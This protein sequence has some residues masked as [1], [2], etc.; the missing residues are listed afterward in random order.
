MA[1]NINNFPSERDG[2]DKAKHDL[3]KKTI[4]DSEVDILGLTELGRNEFNIPYSVRPS[5]V[6]QTWVKN[7]L[8]LSAW[9]RR[10]NL[11][12]YEPGV[13][14]KDRSTAHTIKRGIDERN[15]GRWTWV[16]VKGKQQ[17]KTSV[18][19]IYRATNKQ[20]A[21]QNQLGAIRKFNC[22]QQPEELWEEDLKSLIEGMRYIGEVIVMGDFNDDL[23]KCNC[24]V[25]TFFNQMDM[26]EVLNEKYGPGPPN[27]ALGSTKID[28]IYAT[29][30]IS[31]KQGGY[32][33]LQMKP[34]DHLYPWVD[35]E[36]ADMV[37]SERDDRAPPILRKTTSKIP[38]VR[39]AFNRILNEEVNTRRLHSR[40]ESLVNSARSNKR[41]TAEEKSEYEIIENR[42]RRAVKF[43]DNTCRKAR[44]GKVPFS[45]QQ[46][47]TYGP[48]IY[49]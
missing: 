7:G 34:G 31:I 13:F 39:K 17:L 14:T 16:T 10:N 43:A 32:G 2:L 18:I 44:V 20:V 28:G 41:L 11:S 23:N 1:L 25:N 3:L 30:G 49:T 5:N 8:A 48:D 9:N 4:A 36:V 29:S 27:H 12:M 6:I 24:K 42:L 46:K 37:G 47:K 35:I 21:A 40:A 19:T 45:T 38:S 33:G 22:M 15:L 26:R